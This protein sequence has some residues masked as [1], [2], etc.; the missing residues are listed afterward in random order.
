MT[1]YRSIARHGALGFLL[2]SALCA[3]LAPA[4]AETAKADA[5]RIVSVGGTVTEILYALGAGDR[6]V[7]VDSTS[8][9]PAETRGKPDI[10]YMRQLSPEGIL[11]QKPDLIVAEASA[12]PPDAIAILKASSL[13]L[14]MID[15]DPAIEAVGP[16][17]R[18]VG[19][20]VGLAAQAETLAATVEAEITA[21][22]ARSSGLAGQKK[23][24][25]FA[26]SVAN[27]RV[28][29]AGANSA[30]DTMIR[31]AGGI[32]AASAMTGYKPMT[33]EAIIAA[34]PDVILVMAHSA[35]HIDAAQAFAIP[36]LK[37][38]PAGAA[39]ALISMDGLYLLG[40]GPRSAR[41]ADELFGKLYPQAAGQ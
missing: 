37:A 32:N 22:K 41:A 17:I 33:D 9:F 25:L 31:L 34:R 30:A 2:L 20:A 13:P 1:L 38:T 18:A 4:Q 28:M 8:T 26:L 15:A 11:A 3:D 19:A 10:G 27:G 7:A 40:L 5:G 21:I 24:V 36:A 29:A 23:R 35:L 14:A 12:G 39:G 16:R 6:I